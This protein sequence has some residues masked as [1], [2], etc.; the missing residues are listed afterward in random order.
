[1]MLVESV[2]SMV[3]V[4]PGKST[5]VS[6]PLTVTWVCS[7]GSVIS[8]LTAP[9]NLKALVLAA[10]ERDR[11]VAGKVNSVVSVD[12]TASSNEPP[13]PCGWLLTFIVNSTDW[14]SAPVVPTTSMV[15]VV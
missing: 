2:A 4:R 14:L 10:K 11:V 7:D 8:V 6:T 3:V 5:A 13:S 15:I 12:P 9:S 1:M